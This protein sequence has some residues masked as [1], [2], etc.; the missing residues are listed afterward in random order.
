MQGISL[1]QISLRSGLSI[2]ELE[3]Y[4]SGEE[5]PAYDSFKRICRALSVSTG[6]FMSVFRW[7]Y[8]PNMK[9]GV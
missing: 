2:Y 8:V 3:L 5:L 1:E 9:G 4:E 6:Y 7:E